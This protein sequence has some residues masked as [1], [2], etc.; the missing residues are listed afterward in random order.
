MLIIDYTSSDDEDNDNNNN[1]NKNKKCH[2]D[3]TEMFTSPAK[4]ENPVRE[5]LACGKH[6]MSSRTG[7]CFFGSIDGYR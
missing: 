2:G 6:A 1:K 4:N 7:L 5:D 3:V